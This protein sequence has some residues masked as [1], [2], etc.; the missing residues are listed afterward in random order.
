MA[1]APSA[2]NMLEKERYEDTVHSSCNGQNYSETISENERQSQDDTLL[3][4]CMRCEDVLAQIDDWMAA[5][6]VAQEG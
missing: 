4:I 2:Y 1:A 5:D 3:A 6:T